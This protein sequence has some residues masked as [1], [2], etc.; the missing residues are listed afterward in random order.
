MVRNDLLV[1]PVLIP[2]SWRPSRKLYLPYPDRWYALNIRPYD[3]T[4]IDNFGEALQEP[5]AGGKK[6]EFDAHISTDEAQLPYQTPM[7]IREG[8]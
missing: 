3:T 4:S 7:Y 5:V 6:I 2:H 1:A 8:M